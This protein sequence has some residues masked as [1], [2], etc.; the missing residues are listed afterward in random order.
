M[1]DTITM[2]HGGGIRSGRSTISSCVCTEPHA[3]NHIDT[4]THTRAQTP[5]HTPGPVAPTQRPSQCEH[6]SNFFFCWSPL[7]SPCLSLVGLVISMS[8]VAALNYRCPL[9]VVLVKYICYPFPLF[10]FP[11]TL[12]PPVLACVCSVANDSGW[13]LML[14]DGWGR[15]IARNRARALDREDETESEKKLIQGIRN[16][17]KTNDVQLKWEWNYFLADWISGISRTILPLVLHV[18]RIF[19]HT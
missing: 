11:L 7:L 3:F 9:V 5:T 10:P 8:L 1:D 16:K 12:M 18:K 19:A 6:F 2:V 14:D 13:A 4:H 17:R 15:G